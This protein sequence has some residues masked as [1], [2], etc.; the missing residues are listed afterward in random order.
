MLRGTF[1]ALLLLQI[2]HKQ[3]IK[4]HRREVKLRERTT[5]NQTGDAFTGIREQNIRAVSAQAMR[6][7]SAVDTAD[8][9]NA[10]LLHFTQES[11]IFANGRGYSHT[12]HHFIHFISQLRRSR[13]QIQLNVWFPLFLKHLWRVRRFKRNVFRVNA[14]N[15]KLHFVGVMF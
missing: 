12:Q 5:R 9:E 13:V 11:G 4:V 6:H 10:R 1:F 7:L 15:L 2:V 14:L 8:G 3:R